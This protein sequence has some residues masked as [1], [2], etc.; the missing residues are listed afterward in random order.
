LG[1]N[2]KVTNISSTIDT[3]KYKVKEQGPAKQNI[4]IGWSGST[5]TSFYLH[6]LDNALKALQDKF[7]V[8]IKVIGD[9]HFSIPGV[10]VKSCPWVAS[11]EVDD[12]REIDIGLYP[13][14]KDTWVLGK[15][16]LKALQY[17]GLGIPVVAQAIGTNLEIIRDG[18]N[19][20]LADSPDEWLEKISLLI[21]EDRL[22]SSMGSA[23]RRTVE[24]RYS[25]KVNAPIYLDIIRSVYSAYRCGRKA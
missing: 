25:V 15:S 12:L 22:R 4:T 21:R 1:F 23:A 19:G 6:L 18:V 17:M 3:D 13:L 8:D 24:E 20:F 7:H 14:S 9:P 10:K 2:N 16:G 5:T 11:T